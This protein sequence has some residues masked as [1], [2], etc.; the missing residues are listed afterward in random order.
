MP[1]GLTNVVAVAGGGAHSLALGADGTVTAWGA[2]WNGQC[3]FP[4]GLAPLRASPPGNTTRSS[5]W[6]TACP[7]R[8]CCNPGWQTNQFS[9]HVQTLSPKNYALELKGSL[10]PRIG[11]R[12]HQRRQRRAPEC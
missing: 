9:A 7:C 6:P 2:D 1:A 3:D 10:R 8:N 4:P 5:F 11:P 12:V